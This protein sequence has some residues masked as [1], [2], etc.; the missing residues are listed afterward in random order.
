MRHL[1]VHV[2]FCARR[3][4]YCDFAIAVRRRVPSER[5][6]GAV[7]A[8]YRARHETEQWGDGGFETVYLGG[9]TPSQLPPDA[10]RRL[11]DT[12]PRAPNAEVTLEAN[13]DDVTAQAV[14]A[15]RAAGVNRV[16]LGIQS[17]DDRVLAWMHRLHDADAARRAFA[18]LR[19]GG[20]PSVSTDLIFAL[21]GVLGHDVRSDLDTILALGPDHVSAYGLTLEPRTPYARWAHRGTAPPADDERYAAEFQAVH[22]AL[23][24]TGFEHYEVSNYARP[25]ARSRHNSAYWVGA[26]YVGLGPAAHGLRGRERRWN[27]RDWA[28][29]E[30][31]AVAGRD[32]VADRERLDDGQRFLERVFL[33]L[34][35]AEGLPA[36]D[37]ER[38]APA[39]LLAAERAGWLTV[40]DR[41]RP[42][43]A[44]W[45][46][47]EA[48]VASLTTLPEGG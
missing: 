35:T 2:P 30:P 24:G 42:T 15:W 45:L 17:F 11:L 22:D 47:V 14:S 44:G 39:P 34:R 32:P 43:P 38:L 9:G 3:C 46:V 21:P 29:Y 4:S 23:T 27:L 33:G 12:F 26:N 16:S 6:V 37:A 41:V 10:V 1:Y 5:F 7:G 31:V 36:S 28:A 20:I 18:V 19:E 13:P 25:G 40:S 8:E 48:L